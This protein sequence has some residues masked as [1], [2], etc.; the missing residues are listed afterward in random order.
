MYFRSTLCPG[1][2]AAA[3]GGLQNTLIQEEDETMCE[4]NETSMM[5]NTIMVSAQLLDLEKSRVC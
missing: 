5:D 1:P 4:A 3:A 2:A